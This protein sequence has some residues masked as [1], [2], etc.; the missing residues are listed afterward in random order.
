[1]G[2]WIE[3]KYKPEYCQTVIEAFSKGKSK[4]YLCCKLGITRP[5][6]HT[7]ESTYPEFASAMNHG[8]QHAQAYW[9]ELGE[10][11]IDGSIEKFAAAP[12]I[13]SMKNRFRDDYKDDKKDET[14]EAAS[15]LEKIM[16]GELKVKQ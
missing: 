9:E 11:G 7:W 6:L 16:T 2:T 15:L 13:F 10:N 5:T 8:L 3:S 4:A 1:M 14:N 12:W